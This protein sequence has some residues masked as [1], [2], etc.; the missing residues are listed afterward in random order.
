MVRDRGRGCGLTGTHDGSRQKAGLWDQELPD[1]CHLTPR[2]TAHGS[3]G[4]FEISF[5]GGPRPA[6]PRLRRAASS[7]IRWNGGLERRLRTVSPR[8]LSWTFDTRPGHER[9]CDR[10]LRRVLPLLLPPGVK[11]DLYPFQRE[12]VAWLLQNRKAI[13]ADDMGL[14]KTIQVIGAIRRLYRY[15]RIES[16]LIVA[17]GTLLANWL[18]EADKWAPEL[19]T[20][21][22]EFTNRTFTPAR[23]RGTVARAH[24]LLASYEDLRGLWDDLQ[25]QPPDLI[26]A[27]EA[28]RLRKADSLT[29]QA[30]RRIAAPRLWALTGTPVERDAQDLAC[31]LSLLE[32]RRFAIDDHRHGIDVIRARARPYLLR[33]TKDLVLPELPEATER[34][35]TVELRPAQRQAYNRALSSVGRRSEGGHLAVFNKLRSICDID[36]VTGESS[37]LDR[38]A[39]LIESAVDDGCKTVVFSY[40]LDPLRELHKRLTVAHGDIA[41]LLTGEQSLDQ[42]KRSVHRFKTQPDC[43]V[44]LASTRVASEG[45]TL[46][47][48]NRVILL[49]RWWNPSTNSQAVDRVV[50]I[51]QRKPVTVHCLTCANTVEDRLQPLLDRKAMTFEQLIETLRHRPEAAHELLDL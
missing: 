7:L 48:A 30:M 38:A 17:P 43:W 20:Q 9:S 41:A 16:C 3:I 35:E 46:T 5:A 37:K 1:A 14:G 23:W 28:H 33:R 25:G 29:H 21:R 2:L 18:A 31:L 40:M 47:E 10:R 45:L 11:D 15:G 24:V 51:G 13:L 26:V 34:I 4:T 27:D 50:R 12:G 19:I 49:N 22:L 8:P 36:S 32:P 44:L 39:E 42:R 6:N